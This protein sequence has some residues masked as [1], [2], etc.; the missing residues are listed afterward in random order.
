[1]KPKRISSS[2]GQCNERLRR[3]RLGNHVAL[4]VAREVAEW[5]LL[6]GAGARLARSLDAESSA[7]NLNR[8]FVDAKLVGYL[9]LTA[10]KDGESN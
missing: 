7:V 6:P 2:A 1:M 10:P 5:V 8:D 9:L 3:L 4:I